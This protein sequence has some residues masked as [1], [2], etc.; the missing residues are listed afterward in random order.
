[1]LSCLQ[2]SHW[3]SQCYEGSCIVLLLYDR[4]LKCALSPQSSTLVVLVLS[5]ADYLPC[6]VLAV[7]YTVHVHL[8]CVFSTD[9]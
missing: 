2:V 6:E 4:I 7:L 8:L 3:P 1:M 9:V 5:R